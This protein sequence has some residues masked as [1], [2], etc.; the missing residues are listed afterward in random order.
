MTLT[1]D[2]PRHIAYLEHNSRTDVPTA[3]NRAGLYAQNDDRNF[4]AVV[5]VLTG[6]PAYEAGL[7]TGDR[8]VAIDGTPAAGITANDFWNLLHGPPGKTLAFTVDRDGATRAITVTLRNI[9]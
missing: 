1:L 4:F 5:G 2:E 9:V 3:A 7:R 8:I 6:G